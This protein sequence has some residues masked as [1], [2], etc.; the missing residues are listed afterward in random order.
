[1][2]VIKP[3]RDNVSIPLLF[4]NPTPVSKL[5][6]VRNLGDTGLHVNC[7]SR[8]EKNQPGNNIYFGSCFRSYHFFFTRNYFAKFQGSVPVAD[9]HAL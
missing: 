8:V 5:F 6:F 2:P 9:C 7:V 3:I 4:I 1:M